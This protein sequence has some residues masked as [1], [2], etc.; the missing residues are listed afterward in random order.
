M[1][2]KSIIIL[3]EGWSKDQCR[4]IC[5][6]KLLEELAS[7]EGFFKSNK[8]A[9]VGIY[10][11]S[12]GSEQR[13]IYSCPKYLDINLEMPYTQDTLNSVK[14]HMNLITRTIERLRKEGKRFEDSEYEFSEYNS[15]Q[16]RK[17]VN[18]YEL[19]DFILNDY[20]K[21]NLFYHTN[22]KQRI[23][24]KGRTSWSKTV[25]KLQPVIEN[26]E[27]IYT[28]TINRFSTKDFSH[29]LTML[30]K[31]IIN[32]CADF[33]QPLGKYED[34]EL[35]QCPSEIDSNLKIYYHYIL[36][37]LS[38]VYTNRDV[39]LL[40]ALASWCDA[41]H[42]YKVFN[43][44][45]SFDKVWE[46]VTKAVLGNIE[47][48]SSKAP[49]YHMMTES[50]QH[51]VYEGVGQEIPDIIRIV[52]NNA[53]IGV[54]I[55]DAKYYYPRKVNESKNGNKGTIL[56]LP[57]NSDIVKQIAYYNN[58]KNTYGE[59][60]HYANAF[61]IPD[62]SEQICTDLKIKR[63]SSDSLY[64]YRGYVTSGI[65]TSIQ[66]RLSKYGYDSK[67]T[68]HLEEKVAIFTVSPTSLYKYYLFGNNSLTD[69]IIY[70]DFIE[71]YETLPTNKD[72]NTR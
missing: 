51:D 8:V 68:S 65:N 4:S 23:N 34:I 53:N 1:R 57:A 46:Y 37:Q 49:S 15:Y 11:S 47:S 19:A 22:K 31:Y 14:E 42:F 16:Q 36:T 3:K 20:V 63:M 40:K 9:F 21:N 17:N 59:E 55:L 12:K 44:V 45:T 24:G 43:G 10:T 38:Y 50:K 28:H 64:Q 30:H 25:N 5:E 41:S 32:K 13:I 2:S 71:V 52:S 29:L 48:T 70:K 26:E 60:L 39:A 69:Q 72:T 58:F 56:G 6:S 35:P 33:L 18:L 67:S 61:L 62:F 7:I 27:I 66:S 54:C